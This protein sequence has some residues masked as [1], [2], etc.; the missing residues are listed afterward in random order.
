MI[1][2][3]PKFGQ[4]RVPVRVNPRATEGAVFGEDLW[5]RDGNQLRLL[6]LADLGIT[7]EPVAA[8]DIAAVVAVLPIV[9]SL[10]GRTGTI[11]LWNVE[12]ETG[13]ARDLAQSDRD[14]LLRFTNAAAKTFTVQP[15]AS[16]AITQDTRV[17]VRNVGAGDLTVTAGVGVTINADSLVIPQNGTASLIRV[18]EDVWDFVPYFFESGVESVNGRTGAVV[19]TAADVPATIITDSTTARD[20]S[21]SDMGA[22]LRFTNAAAKALTVRDNADVAITT[23]LE[24]HGRNA[25]AGDLTITEDTAVTVNTPAGGTLVVPQGGTFTLKK[26]GTDEW[27]LFGVTVAL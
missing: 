6:T 14:K 15:N 2:Q 27:D 24:V 8:G 26:V 21:A 22:Y 12:T 17:H 23:G 18:A 16:V 19:L 1:V 4:P 13:T 7:Q 25:G 3:V 5:I 20:L 9:Q 10:D 11:I